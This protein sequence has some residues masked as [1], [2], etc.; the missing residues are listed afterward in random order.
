MDVNLHDFQAWLRNKN[1][2][3]RTI[4]NYLYY[5]G[6]F[7]TF[8]L[9]NQESVARFMSKPS[10][11]NSVA[12]GFLLN[13]KKFLINNRESLGLSE[14][15]YRSIVEVELPK[16]SGRKKQRLINPLSADKIPLLESKLESEKLKIM[17]LLT[18]YGALR[19]GELYKLSINSFNWDDWKTDPEKMG[20]VRVFGKGDKEGICVIPGF[21]M[22]RIAKFIRSSA[23]YHG[24]PVT[25]KLFMN[26]E[27]ADIKSAG[28]W[29]QKKLRQAGIDSG[30]TIID[31]EGKP[32]KDTI[33]HPHRLRHS[34][35]TFVLKEKKKD[36]RI[37][38]EV[39]RHSS[40]SSTQ[41]Y[42]HIDKDHLKSELS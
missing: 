23:E 35:A 4:E 6:H 34:F 42:T 9:Y 1:L 13:L 26:R 37:V 31:P 17:L 36:I 14:S 16:I 15:Y 24:K 39:L 25:T 32:L 19:L 27:S 41:I 22:K 29:W 10:N 38:Q 20:E 28:S 3:P 18:Y 33:V 40:I 8:D 2:K 12:R 30:I 7:V 21:L 11:Q 5:L